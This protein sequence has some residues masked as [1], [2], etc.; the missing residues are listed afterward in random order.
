MLTRFVNM[1]KFIDLMGVYHE[2]KRTIYEEIDYVR[3]AENAKRFQE[4]FKEHPMIHIPRVYDEYVS[5]RVL[6]LEWID[7]IK[8]NDYAALAL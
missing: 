1:D 2:F 6:V 7:G 4:M 3:E 8:I 5:R